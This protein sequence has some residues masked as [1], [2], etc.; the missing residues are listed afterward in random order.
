MNL[1]N[2]LI[3]I[4]VFIILIISQ[5]NATELGVR[6]SSRYISEGRDQL[7]SGG[8]YWLNGS[9]KLNDKL[10][11]N[12]EYGFSADDSANYDEL[13]F[14]I[15]YASANTSFDYA[16]TYSHL[17][18][19]EDDVSDDEIS[20]R[21]SYK[22]IEAFSPFANVTYGKEENGFFIE[23]GTSKQFQIN[24][25]IFITPH[26]LFAYDYGYV[27]SRR[28]GYNHTSIGAVFTF[29]LSKTLTVNGIIEQTLGGTILK[30]EGEKADQ[31]WS[32]VH[33][34]YSW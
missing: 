11:I 10:S 2:K 5:V 21:L 8:I 14:A 25:A 3:L 16:I 26:V 31:L 33:L 19:F 23:V 6:Y 29:V 17:T 27:N 1:N 18:F 7:T 15:E 4:I 28:E 12:I 13:N 9:H 34:V 32:G 30:S 24:E 20:L 22:K